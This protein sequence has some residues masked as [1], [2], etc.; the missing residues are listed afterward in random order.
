MVSPVVVF[1]AMISMNVQPK[2]LA[3]KMPN[4]TMESEAI[5]AFAM[6]VSLVMASSVGMSMNVSLRRTTVPQLP[7]ALIQDLDTLVSAPMGTLEMVQ[8]VGISMSA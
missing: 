7:N 1:S 4:V 8:H 6:T 2:I 5:N 3:A